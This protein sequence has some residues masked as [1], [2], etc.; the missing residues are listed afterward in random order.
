MLVLSG[1]WRSVTGGELRTK[2]PGIDGD[3]V[4]HRASRAEPMNPEDEDFDRRVAR[5]AWLFQDSAAAARS[6]FL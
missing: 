4:E 1:K 2:V 3:A 6:E 5:G